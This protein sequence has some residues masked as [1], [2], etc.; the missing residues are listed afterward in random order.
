[1]TGYQEAVTDPSY[2]GQII[3]FTYPLIGNYGVCAAAMESDA[4]PGP[5]RDHAGGE[6]RRGRRHRRGRLARL[7]A[8]LRGAGDRR[9]RHPGARSPHPRP[10]R[11][12]RRD[13]PGR[14][15]RVARRASGSPPSRRW[16]APTSPGRSRRRSRSRSTATV[17]TWSGIDTGIKLSIIRQLRE[18]GCRVTLL[19]CGRVR[20]GGPRATT[21]TWSS[22]PTAPA[23]RRRSTTSSTTVRELVGKRPGGRHLPRPP[24]PLPGGRPRDLQ[25]PLRPPRREPPGQGPRDR[26]DRDHL[27]EPR[28]RGRRARTARRGSR[29]TSR[30]AGRPTSAPPSSPT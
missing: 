2:A 11:D 8:R 30:S 25:A 20:R 28:L 13:L 9:H 5:R 12:A 14:D 17:P 18:R 15:R 6:E 24:A 3:T 19:P 10:R 23:T 21:P 22:S 29:P 7:A 1:M 4:R 27:A 16:R 26:P